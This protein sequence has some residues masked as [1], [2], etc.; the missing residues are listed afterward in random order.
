MTSACRN[1]F[2]QTLIAT[3]ASALISLNILIPSAPPAKE[4]I[5]AQK[6]ISLE[7]RYSSPFVNEVFKD[8][9]LLNLAYLDGRVGR[10]GRASDVNWEDVRKPFRSEF[11]LEQ[12]K[13]FA[14][15][16][17]VFP[18]FADSLV[19]TTNAHFNASDGF[20][21][22]GLLFGDGVCHLAS[23]LNWVAKDAGLE[24]QAPVNHNFREIP[25]IPKQHGVSI[26]YYPGQTAANAYQN[27]YITNS[28]KV[29]VIFRIDY[30]GKQLRVE[31]VEKS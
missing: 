18:E 31:V 8:N 12:G 9:I 13:T 27:L 23:L 1:M 3:V 14:F 19:K 17:D 15:H 26:Y 20:R 28:L 16:E 30:N 24:V 5:R 7:N 11:V 6:E 22:S 29:P 10:V 25:Q 21:F 4:V 2:E